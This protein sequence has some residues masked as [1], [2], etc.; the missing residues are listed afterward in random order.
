M[1]G[2]SRPGESRVRHGRDGMQLRSSPF[3]KREEVHISQSTSWE[4]RE[5]DQRVDVELSD[6]LRQRGER[7]D[8]AERRYRTDDVAERIQRQRGRRRSQ[9]TNA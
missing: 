5:P 2:E 4:A 9:R 7:G 1:S 6:D 3:R 8:I